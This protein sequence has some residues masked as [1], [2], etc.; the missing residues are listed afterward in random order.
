MMEQFRINTTGGCL[1]LSFGLAVSETVVVA[2]L[3]RIRH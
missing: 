3:R 1:L 2:L